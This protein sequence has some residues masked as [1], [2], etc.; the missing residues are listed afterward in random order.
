[1]TKISLKQEARSPDQTGQK[2]RPY[3]QNN[4]NKMRWSL[5]DRVSS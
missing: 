2:M 5:N 3:F 4:K 1:V